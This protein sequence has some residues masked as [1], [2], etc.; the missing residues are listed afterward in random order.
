MTD[1]PEEEQTR[2][3]LFQELVRDG[4]LP[5]RL[6]HTAMYA[7][8]GN[9][10]LPYVRLPDDERYPLRNSRKIAFIPERTKFRDGPSG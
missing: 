9:S 1:I 6:E 5:K 4:Y 2:R 7:P 3:R 8:A 10:Q